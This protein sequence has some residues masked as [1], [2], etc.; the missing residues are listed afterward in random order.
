MHAH[1]HGLPIS[2]NQSTSPHPPPISLPQYSSSVPS[3]AAFCIAALAEYPLDIHQLGLRLHYRPPLHSHQLAEDPLHSLCPSHAVVDPRLWATIV[4]IYDNLPPE[5]SSFI[6][7]LGDVHL[8]LL[9]QIPSTPHFSL[10]TILELPGCYHLTD[11]SISNL[12]HLHTLTAFDATGTNISSLAISSLVN[13]CLW[14]DPVHGDQ[15]RRRGPWSLR[16]LCL[17]DCS[18]VNNAVL[19]YLSAFPLLSVVGM[20]NIGRNL[21]HFFN[22]LYVL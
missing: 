8:P 1:G 15:A 2:A 9:Q 22:L 10:I 17:K 18:R 14:T 20:F 16:V 5:F 21:I 3:L 19:P 11:D 13:T 12:K 7:S 4:Q 6:I